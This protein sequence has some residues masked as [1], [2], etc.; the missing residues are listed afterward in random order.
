MWYVVCFLIICG[1]YRLCLSQNLCKKQEYAVI[2]ALMM[3]SADWVYIFFSS[4]RRLWHYFAL[5][6]GMEELV[7]NNLRVF[8]VAVLNI[9]QLLVYGQCC[10][11][12]VFLYPL[13]NPQDHLKFLI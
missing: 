5:L 11:A 6:L 8:A 12:A 3:P 7:Q 1:G 9:W 10:S 13:P 2:G 4:Y